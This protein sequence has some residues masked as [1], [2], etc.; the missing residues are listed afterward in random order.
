M[1]KV[2]WRQ[3]LPDSTATQRTDPGCGVFCGYSDCSGV[4]DGSIGIDET[5]TDVDM[6]QRLF[7]HRHF[8]LCDSRIIKA[9]LSFIPRLTSLA[10]LT[11]EIQPY[12]RVKGGGGRTPLGETNI[13]AH[14][15]LEDDSRIETASGGAHF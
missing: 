7:V 5:G 1:R 15:R 9:N 2:L 13:P 4:Y 12:G 3:T 10:Y 11:V 8:S 6:L 14:G